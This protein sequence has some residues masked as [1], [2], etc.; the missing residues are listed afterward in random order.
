MH[1]SYGFRSL[2]PQVRVD[3]ALYY[4]EER[5]LI[6]RIV[7]R[8]LFT[9]RVLQRLSPLQSLD[10]GQAAGEP[11]D[12]SLARVPRGRFVGLAGDHVIELHDDVSAQVAFDL[13][14]DLGREESS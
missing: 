3:S 8:H 11:A 6:A 1:R 14:D 5:L 12:A 10:L 7:G 13:H 2:P 4:R 9:W